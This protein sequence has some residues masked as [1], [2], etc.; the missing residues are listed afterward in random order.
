MVIAISSSCLVY[1]GPSSDETYMHHD[2]VWC[3]RGTTNNAQ[4]LSGELIVARLSEE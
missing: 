4:E 3:T 1:A 2:A